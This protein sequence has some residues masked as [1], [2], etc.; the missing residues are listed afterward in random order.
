MKRAS[1]GQFTFRYLDAPGDARAISARAHFGYWRG[2]WHLSDFD[3]LCPSDC[4]F[5]DVYKEP[6]DESNGFLEMLRVVFFQPT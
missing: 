2:A 3:Y 4:H 1:Y 5:V 6:V